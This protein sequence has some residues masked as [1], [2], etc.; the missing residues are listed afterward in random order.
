MAQNTESFDWSNHSDIE[1][2]TYTG[3]FERSIFEMALDNRVIM[4]LLMRISNAFYPN[5]TFKYRLYDEA[6]NHLIMLRSTNGEDL[7]TGK[8]FNFTDLFS[9][10]SLKWIFADKR[11]RPTIIYS[12]RLLVCFDTSDGISIYVKEDLGITH[13]TRLSINEINLMLFMMCR[14][15]N[16]ETIDFSNITITDRNPI[17]LGLRILTIIMRCCGTNEHL[18][19]TQCLVFP[20]DNTYHLTMWG[21][22]G[23]TMMTHILEM[24]CHAMKGMLF[25]DEQIMNALIQGKQPLLNRFHMMA[26]KPMK[27]RVHQT[28]SWYDFHIVLTISE[29]LINREYQPILNGEGQIQIKKDVHELLSKVKELPTELLVKIINSPREFTDHECGHPND[30]DETTTNEVSDYYTSEQGTIKTSFLFPIST[31]KRL[32]SFHSKATDTYFI[33][34][35]A[36]NHEPFNIIGTYA[37]GAF[38]SIKTR[39]QNGHIKFIDRIHFDG[40]I[41]DLNKQSLK[42]LTP[43][44]GTPHLDYRH[45]IDESLNDN[46]FF[47][48]DSQF[49]EMDMHCNC[50]EYYI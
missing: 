44:V 47:M 32:N 13:F 23:F 22:Y 5:L 39:K 40:E 34:R 16:I 26:I 18:V 48:K 15:R 41:Y 27:P 1:W 50:T 49:N 38:T 29:P 30:E 12:E 43:I 10:S 21:R 3:K 46:P 36:F 24:T 35:T 4:H 20:I 33:V 45:K 9:N 8:D 42:V 28:S 31:R 7:E 17:A 37:D 2:K 25:H 14:I 6:Y 19:N 11:Y